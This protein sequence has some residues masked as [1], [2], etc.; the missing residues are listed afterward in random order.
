MRED[1]L[2]DSG[3]LYSLYAENDEHHYEA[4]LVTQLI[5]GRMLIPQVTLGEAAF[6]FRRERNGLR[7]SA[8]FMRILS[9]DEPVMIDVTTTDL[10]RAAEI[11][12]EYEEAKFDF[13]DCCLMALS[14]RLN[15]TMVC[16]FDERDFGIFRPKHA[17][18]LELLP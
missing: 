4:L 10:N 15:I 7:L 18:R 11:M 17:E 12:L 13:V 3:F 5:E 14:E 8:E 6:L 2:V 1:V 16:T 9:R